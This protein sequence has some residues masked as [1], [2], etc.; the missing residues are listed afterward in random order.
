MRDPFA[1]FRK[2]DAH[3]ENFGSVPSRFYPPK[4]AEEVHCI[5]GMHE[6]V[7]NIAVAL[8]W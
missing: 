6:K 8:I 2:V 5:V 3:L 1:E 4:S 7:V